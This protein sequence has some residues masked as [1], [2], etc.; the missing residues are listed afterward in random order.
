MRLYVWT[1][2]YDNKI[3]LGIRVMVF[4]ATF[5]NISVLLVEETEY[6]EK[7]T[8]LHQVTDKVYHIMLCCIEYT[9]PWTGFKLT[10][11]V[12]IGNDC[13]GTCKS[14]CQTTTTSPDNKMN[15]KYH[16]SHEIRE[17]S[18]YQHCRKISEEQI[19]M[20]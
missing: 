17:P 2:N 19:Q 5:N 15:K 8:D 9:S 1:T 16:N 13:I 3:G 14:N 20:L 4:N 12:V 7:I 18:I 10:T 6:S 11:L